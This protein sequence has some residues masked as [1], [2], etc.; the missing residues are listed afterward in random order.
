MR[1][2]DF[3]CVIPAGFWIEEAADRGDAVN[4][5]VR[6]MATSGSCPLCGTLSGRVHSRYERKLND[7]PIGSRCVRLVVRARRFFCDAASCP[8]Q[9][10]AERFDGVVLPRARRTRRLDEVVFCLAIALGDRPAAVLANRIEIKV[11]NDTLL[12]A[13]RRRGLPEPTA[14]SVIGID[15]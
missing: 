5:A 7:L 13:V 8:R 1:L 14:P 10:F 9:I 2:F 12:R 3:S 6:G 15:D 4:V 11:S